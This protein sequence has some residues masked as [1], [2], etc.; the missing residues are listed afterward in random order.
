[1]D[2]SQLRPI[3]TRQAI[4]DAHANLSVAL[5]YGLTI[6]RATDAIDREHVAQACAVLNLIRKANP[7]T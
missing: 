7:L 2:L 4:E 6:G 5:R 1:M 3:D